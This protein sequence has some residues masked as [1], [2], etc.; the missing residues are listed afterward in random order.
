MNALSGYGRPAPPTG[1][2]S[3]R[4]KAE[5]QKLVLSKWFQTCQNPTKEMLSQIS[6]ETMLSVIDVKR[7][8]R[9]RRHFV[10]VAKDLDLPRFDATGP[11]AAAGRSQPPLGFTTAGT[12]QPAAADQ[13]GPALAMRVRAEAAWNDVAARFERA[14]DL[15]PPQDVDAVAARLRAHGIDPS[16]LDVC[17]MI[18]LASMF[19]ARP[20]YLTACDVLTP[21][22]PPRRPADMLNRSIELTRPSRAENVMGLPCQA[23]VHPVPAG[24]LSPPLIRP[25]ALRP[26]TA[27]SIE[28]VPW[29][30]M[31]A[32]H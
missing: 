24:A 25:I 28:V 31:Y 14:S 23:Q 5:Y 20:Q 1:K 21:P 26:T 3:R 9:N 19:D 11:L 6:Q 16:A 29:C 2:A 27:R 30:W 15:I 13:P 17:V 10:K 18:G 32:G 22:Q 12:M 7:W 8:F 4:G